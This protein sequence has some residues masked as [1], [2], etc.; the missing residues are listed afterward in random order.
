MK[1]DVSISAGLVTLKI[2]LPWEVAALIVE[3]GPSTIEQIKSALDQERR[4]N[5]QRQRALALTEG[6]GTSRRER[7]DALARQLDRELRSTKTTGKDRTALVR[8]FADRSGIPVSSLTAIHKGYQQRREERVRARRDAQVIRL[9]LLGTSNREIA[10][11]LKPTITPQSV[12]RILKKHPDLIW[13]L[14]EYERSRKPEK[15]EENC[16]P[17][18]SRESSAVIPGSSE[19][20]ETEQKKRLVERRELHRVLAIRFYRTYRLSR[21]APDAKRAF[22]ASL[23]EPHDFDA[24]YAEHLI[25]RRRQTVQAYIKRRRLKTVSRLVQAGKQNREIA[26]A[27]GLSVNTVSR[28][29]REEKL[30]RRRQVREGYK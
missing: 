18:T 16:G 4:N 13:S 14:K 15:G 29:I 23:A 20:A 5:E 26:G 11:Q 1:R 27:L 2:E 12:G 21:P 7:W 3:H 19:N 22:L 24:N 25:S 28:F 8:R 10:T 6:D 9:H 17:G 30:R